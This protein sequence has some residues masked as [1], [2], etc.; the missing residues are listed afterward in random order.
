MTKPEDIPQ[1][2]VD[3]FKKAWA[4]K[5]VEVGRGIPTP[6]EK[7]RAGLSAVY[8]AIGIDKILEGRDKHYFDGVATSETTW[9]GLDR[10]TETHTDDRD[11]T[12]QTRWCLLTVF[13]SEHFW[14]PGI[15]SFKC[16]GLHRHLSI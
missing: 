8:E 5:G 12:Y 2:A 1:V 10:L 7:T 16:P 11:G 3:A 14:Y 15:E 13:H 9:E 4:A 6:G